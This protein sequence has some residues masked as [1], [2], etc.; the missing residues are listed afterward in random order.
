[1]I[2]SNIDVLAKE[3]EQI[4]KEVERKLKAMVSG[5]AGEVALKASENTPVASPEIIQRYEASYRQRK[6]QYGVEMAPGYHAGA[7]KYIEGTLVFNDP[8]IY[9]RSQVE[10]NAESTA[11]IQYKLGDTFRIGAIGF[12]YQALEGGSST[13]AKQGIIAPTKQAVIAAFSTN[14]KPFYD[15]G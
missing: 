9:G 11:K 3:L 15:R 6:D 1:M 7:W 13:Q 10:T 4:E 2:T 14:V 8:N 12:A 5:F